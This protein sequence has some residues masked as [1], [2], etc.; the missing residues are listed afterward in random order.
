MA[1]SLPVRGIN[2]DPQ[3]RCEHYHGPTDIVAI[4]MKC[5]GVYYACKDC[6]AALA[7][8]PMDVWPESDWDQKAILCGACKT[9]LSIRQYK[10][11]DFSCPVCRERFNPRCKNHDHF[12]FEVRQ[13]AD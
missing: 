8:H 1:S 13:S 5:C 10:M 7:E 4:K 2:L 12:Y 11:S 9:Q 6:H 3:T